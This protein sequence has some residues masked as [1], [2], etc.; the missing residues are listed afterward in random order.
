[1]NLTYENSDYSSDRVV[2]QILLLEEYGAELFDS[3]GENKV[4]A[5]AL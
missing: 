5:N 4:F 1:M 2:R 3:K